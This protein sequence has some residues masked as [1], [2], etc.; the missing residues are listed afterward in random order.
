MKNSLVVGCGGTGSEIIKLLKLMNV[1]ITC[2][3]YDKVELT[4]LNR[5]FYFIKS[6]FNKYKAEIVAKKI[7]C[8]YRNVNL[9]DIK[10]DYLNQF[11]VIFSCLDSI[12]ARMELNYRFKQSKCKKLVDL[13]V[14]KL[15]SH[16][17]IITDDK[18][19]LYCMKDIFNINEPYNSCTFMNIKT[20][21]D[22]FN[23][24][25]YL[26]SLI[27]LKGNDFKEIV[28]KFNN[29]VND[30]KLKTNLLEVE[31]IFHNITPNISTI[32]SITASLAIHLSLN[33]DKNDL[34]TF[35]GKTF[36]IYKTHLNKDE[37][38]FVCLNKT[39]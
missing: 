8:N 11:D 5:Q 18:A 10:I 12:G 20:K 39:D 9:M 36:T 17:K 35:W 14:E 4:N 2:I 3:D 33:E 23:R 15:T 34:I 30:E 22:R 32:N 6:D 7:G 16:I 28:K 1:N 13:G 27:A 29:K 26:I 25:K 37:D 38:C 31:T 19:C 24:E 21:I